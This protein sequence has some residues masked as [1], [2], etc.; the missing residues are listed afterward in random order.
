MSLHAYEAAKADW[1]RRHPKATPEE[2]Q[3]A[4]AAL[5]RRYGV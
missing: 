3:R 2:Y 5:A 4:M 1:I